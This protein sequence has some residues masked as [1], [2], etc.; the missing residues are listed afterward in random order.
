MADKFCHEA[1]KRLPTEAEWEF[2]ARGPDGRKYPWGDDDPGPGLLNACGKECMAWGQKN[3]IDEKAMY[4][5]DDGFANTAPVGSFPKGASRYGVKDVVGN[6]WEWVADYYGPYK[7]DEQKEPA[8]P[9]R[10]DRARHP[11]RGVERVVRRRGCGRRSATRTRRPSEATASGSAAR[12]DSGAGRERA[13]SSLGGVEVS[14]LE[15]LAADGRLPV[16]L[17]ARSHGLELV[18]TELRLDER[19]EIALEHVGVPLELDGELAEPRLERG[20]VLLHED[21]LKHGVAHARLVF[22][23]GLD[24]DGR[25]IGHLA[26]EERVRDREVRHQLLDEAEDQGQA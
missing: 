24:A 7:S 14:C 5:V 11:R 6:V 9:G 13:P 15:V 25:R 12:S 3:G 23:V 20:V 2:A 22:P 1:G 10:G 8:R 17:H 16:R 21:G 18:D 4:D 26:E 19:Q